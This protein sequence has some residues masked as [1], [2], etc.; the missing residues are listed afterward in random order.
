MRICLLLGFLFGEMAVGAIA[1]AEE[2][3]PDVSTPFPYG[4]PPIDYEDESSADPIAQLG[5]K[6]DARQ[7]R[8]KHEPSR[9]YLRSLLRALDIPVESQVLVYSKTSLNRKLISPKNPRAIYFNDQTYV[10]WTPGSTAL[11]ISTVDPQKGGMFYTLPQ[12]PEQPA[13]FVRATNCLTCHVTT[14]TLQVPGHLARSFFTDHRGEPL[15]GRSLINH[16]SPLNKRWG[17]WY[18]TGDHGDQPHMGNVIGA[19]A[20]REFRK[21]PLLHGNVNDL[22]S[23]FDVQPYLTPHSDIVAL[24]VMEHQT[25]LQNLLTRLNYETRLERESTVEEFLLRY[26]FFIDEPPLTEEV[27]GDSGFTGAFEFY[28]PEDSRGRSLRQF[29]LETRLFKY[30]L[31]YQIYAPA[32]QQLPAAAKA[33]LYKRIW[34]VLSGEEPGQDFQKIPLAERKA[35]LEI[36]RDTVPDLPAY[37]R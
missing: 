14:N 21:D 17:G 27:F 19:D 33:R 11:E 13:K 1:L 25:Y 2:R 7:V 5:K 34:N 6:L 16:D 15:N 28:G 24:M 4:R 30:R 20:A 31:S 18:V 10:S 12:S 29:D 35:I 9:G 3:G 8:L 37:F 23:F 32:F 22:S 36:L 26:L